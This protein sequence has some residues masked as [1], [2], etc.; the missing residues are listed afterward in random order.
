MSSFNFTNPK[1]RALFDSVINEA[2]D[3]HGID[4]EY[5]T[6]TYA[7]K[8]KIYGEDSKPLVDAR[9]KLRA[10]AE[11]IQEDYILT[12]FGLG[13]SDIFTIDIGISEFKAC[14]GLEPKTGDFIWVPYMERL[15]EVTDIDKENAI[16]LQKKFTY[17][18]HLK[19]ADISG[20]EILDTLPLTDYEN[21]LDAQ[22]DNDAVSIA[23]SGVIVEKV[24]DEDPFGEWS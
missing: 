19:T 18:I 21:V 17:S 7:E 16:F 3:M 10:Y 8:D 13:S 15:F 11:L 14:T 9:Y 6:A 22:N 23:V 5:Y 24:G 4:V 1:D 2:I 20:E 12:R